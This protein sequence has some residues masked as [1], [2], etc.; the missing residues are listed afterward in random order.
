MISRELA[1]VV[2]KY[3]VCHCIWLS[4]NGWMTIFFFLLQFSPMWAPSCC[5]IRWKGSQQRTANASAGMVCAL[6]VRYNY[7]SCVVC[8][9][10]SLHPTAFLSLFHSKS[11]NSITI[12]CFFPSDSAIAFIFVCEISTKEGYLVSIGWLQ[13]HILR[14]CPKIKYGRNVCAVCVRKFAA[15]GAGS[16]LFDQNPIVSA[17]ECKAIVSI[18]STDIYCLMLYCVDAKIHAKPE[19]AKI[20]SILFIQ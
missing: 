8:D 6:T 5:T 4:T 1:L 11:A 18:Y 19:P 16:P 15:L 12:L 17:C 13:F 7:K 14:Q 10:S 3:Y 2:L 20:G 9:C